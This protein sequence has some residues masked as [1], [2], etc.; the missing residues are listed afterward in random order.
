M[1]YYMITYESDKEYEPGM[2]IINNDS[3]QFTFYSVVDIFNFMDGGIYI[4]EVVLPTENENFKMTKNDKYNEY[5]A[6]MVIVGQ[7]YE[8]VRPETFKL[9]IEQGADVSINDFY[10]L[11]WNCENNH[12]DTVKYLF[13]IGICVSIDRISRTLSTTAMKGHLDIIRYLVEQG[14]NINSNDNSA[15]KYSSEFGH[16]AVVQYLVTNGADVQANNN[17]A[18]RLACQNGH[19]DVVQY[20]VESSANVNANNGEALISSAEKGHTDIVRYLLKNGAGSKNDNWFMRWFGQYDS[21]HGFLSK[22][23]SDDR[24]TGTNTDSK[25]ILDEISRNPEQIISGLLSHKLA[26]INGKSNPIKEFLEKESKTTSL[27]YALK[28]SCSKGHFD[29]V[30]LL[31]ESGANIHINDDYPLRISSKENYVDIVK[32]LIKSGA[33]IHAGKNESLL[34]NAINGNLDIVKSL[35]E[36]G[37]N[38]NG[39]INI[40]T[41][42]AENNHLDVIKLLIESGA[43]DKSINTAFVCSVMYG[44][45]DIVKYLVESGADIH[46]KDNYALKSSIRFKHLDIE[47]YLRTMM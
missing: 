43:N 47:E 30:K 14:S 8:L 38:V 17:Y 40:I 5:Y 32:L 31:I 7:K 25:K 16:L 11:T 34:H 1:T 6:N 29:I 4:I 3:S 35:L 15:L 20:L 41:L 37:A 44:H 19:M 23:K 42:A 13:S 24:L 18:L 27:D 36:A 22:I 26:T 28:A 9:L 45:L 10:V 21:I 33:N 2:N 46:Y 39:N 12:L